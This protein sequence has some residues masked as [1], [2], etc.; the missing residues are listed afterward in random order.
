[1]PSNQWP[2]L[3][4]TFGSFIL[5]GSFSC[6]HALPHNVAWLC[7]A[8]LCMLYIELHCFTLHCNAVRTTPHCTA[9]HCNTRVSLHPPSAKRPPVLELFVTFSTQAM[10]SLEP[11]HLLSLAQMCFGCDGMLVQGLLLAAPSKVQAGASQHAAEAPEPSVEVGDDGL[12]LGV[13]ERHSLSPRK[14]AEIP[15]HL[16]HLDSWRLTELRTFRQQQAQKEQT[17]EDGATAADSDGAKRQLTDHASN[18]QPVTGLPEVAAAVGPAAVQLQRK[19]TAE[20]VIADIA[21]PRAA[22]SAVQ[23]LF[24]IHQVPFKKPSK[25]PSMHSVRCAALPAQMQR[26]STSPAFC[27]PTTADKIEEQSSMA[28]RHVLEASCNAGGKGAQEENLWAGIGGFGRNGRCRDAS[29]TA[30]LQT[31]RI[32]SLHFFAFTWLNSCTPRQ[33]RLALQQEHSHSS[34]QLHRL[35]HLQGSLHVLARHLHSALVCLTCQR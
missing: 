3:Y 10:K 22:E 16:Q 4:T 6:N 7:I 1:M 31:P 25:R 21:P 13:F 5:V 23:S 24:R 28:P 8:W 20:C 2:A 9:L 32:R 29:S 12:P 30:A 15:T 11:E 34:S 14:T 27:I 18:D 17:S 33:N 35:C 26:H 19:L